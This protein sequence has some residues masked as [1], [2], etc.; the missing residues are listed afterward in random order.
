[1]PK[2]YH[3]CDRVVGDRLGRRTAGRRGCIP[4]GAGGGEGRTGGSGERRPKRGWGAHERR[5]RSRSGWQIVYSRTH[6]RK[7]KEAVTAVVEE[8]A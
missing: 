4:L 5:R 1:M 3:A 8:F 6:R 2:M 7:T